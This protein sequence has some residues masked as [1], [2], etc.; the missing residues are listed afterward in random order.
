[1]RNFVLLLEANRDMRWESTET[2]IEFLRTR[3]E[4]GSVATFWEYPNTLEHRVRLLQKLLE[5]KKGFRKIENLLDFG[6]LMGLE[7]TTL[8]TTN[9]C[10]NQLSYN[11]RFNRLQR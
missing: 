3:Y 5:T 11:H 7:P 6:W 2:L 1:M 10:S 8:G 9:R 4:F